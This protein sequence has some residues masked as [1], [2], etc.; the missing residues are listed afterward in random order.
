MLNVTL[1][2]TKLLTLL[3]ATA[4]VFPCAGGQAEDSKAADRPVSFVYEIAPI[5][6]HRCE[7]CHGPRR[8]EGE[9]EVTSYDHTMEEVTPGNPRRSPLYR[10]L[11]R[12][13]DARRMP[14][15]KAA[16]PA[17]EIELIK[18]WIESGAE[19]D[20]RDTTAHLRDI[21]PRPVHRVAPPRY[22]RPV[23]LTAVAFSHD[24]KVL[25][26]S[27][28]HEVQIWDI[29]TQSLTRRVS[30]VAERTYG[31]EFSPDGQFLAV[32]SGTPGEYGEVAL[33]ET[34][35]GDLVQPLALMKDVALSV[36]F[37]PDGL[38]LATTGADAVIRVFKVN[39]GHDAVEEQ[40]FEHHSDW[41]FDVAWNSDGSRLA[42]ASRDK[43]SKVFS[44]KSG[45][46]ESTYTGHQQAI[47]GVR[48]SKDGKFVYSSGADN[49]IHFWNSAPSITT[50]MS[51]K[52]DDPKVV[53]KIGGF[54]LP[55][56]GVDAHE[57]VLF[58]FSADGRVQ[59]HDAAKRALLT[60]FS[61]HRARVYA[62]DYHPESRRLATGS[63]DGEV[64]IWNVDDGKSLHQFV[65]APGYPAS[66]PA[67]WRRSSF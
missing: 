24:G 20:G 29:E 8:Q 21:L 9:Y 60:E 45:E 33:F 26:T 39:S 67:G 19:F 31:L 18:R 62:L 14:K 5:L 16:L 64:R 23:P 66:D 28:Y 54:T 15:N 35:S 1:R 57:D 61:G 63:F 43:T 10:L 40:V 52:G 3:L 41:V 38:H 34:E 47:Y 55:V 12:K 17:R 13:D 50:A 2:K 11:L 65:A 48:F 25:A 6:V 30:S 44:I 27:G 37:S 56:Y 7:S 32:A 58:S 22:E 4:G 46:I 53:H 42:S 36:K 59:M 51:E 49:R